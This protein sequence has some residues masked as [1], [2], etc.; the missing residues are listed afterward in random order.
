[1]QAA[2]PFFLFFHAPNVREKNMSSEEVRF[3]SPEEAQ[4]VV[5]AI[6]EEEDIY[7]PGHRIM[8]VYNQDNKEICWFDFDEL[9]ADIG[10]V[11]KEEE[12]EVVCNYIMERI[13]DWALEI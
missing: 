2:C 4:K 11:D 9:M 10:S 3:L 13:P 7:N 6:Q 1:V 5:A 8:T 12:K